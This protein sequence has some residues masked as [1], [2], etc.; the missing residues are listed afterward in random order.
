MPP[1]KLPRPE[2]LS[3]AGL[4][5][6][7][8][9]AD[10]TELLKALRRAVPSIVAIT[11]M[12]TVL[13]FI[14]AEFSAIVE[15]RL[16]NPWLT[17][18]TGCVAFL[19]GTFVA[20]MVPRWRAA[21]GRLFWTRMGQLSSIAFCLG[22]A[23]SVWILMPPAN[24]I[25]RMLMVL[26]CMWFIAMV[27]IL[28][29]DRVSVGGA[30]AVVGSMAIFTLAYDL[31]HALPL[32]GFLIM[33][34]VALVMIRRMIWR[35]AETLEIALLLVRSERDAKTRFIASASHDLQQPLLAASLYFGHAISSKDGS[36]RET[37]IAGAHQAFASTRALL[38]AMLEHLRLEAGAETARNQDF[39]L[40]KVVRDAVSEQAA[41][42]RAAGVRLITVPF[43]QNVCA[44]P[45]L[46][47][48][49]LGNLLGNAIKHAGA[50][51]VLIGATQ[52]GGTLLLWIIDDG[53]GIAATDADLVFKDYV[54]G[55]QTIRHPGG[56]GL[57]LA[58]SRRMAELMNATLVLDQRW[59]RGCAFVLKLPVTANP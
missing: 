20:S 19:T 36:A 46:I 53:C 43:S 3:L 32:A 38:Q 39:D 49:I 12:S 51:R 59:Q 22:I 34:G 57:G 24:D 17:Y 47:S 41:P 27:I 30:V 11:V 58:S 40:G 29:A 5:Q 56:F 16:L 52:R 13:L 1:L 21:R 25:L 2:S 6:T 48:R 55:T 7:R 23:I 28:N 44:D 33:E 26:L 9:P 50:Q 18:M 31:P 10:H 37:A 45:L 8:G 14:R 4:L 42:S 54:Q 35:A 15:P